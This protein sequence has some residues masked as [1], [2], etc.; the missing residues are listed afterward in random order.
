MTALDLVAHPGE[1]EKAKEEFAK[2]QG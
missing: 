1:L 2:T